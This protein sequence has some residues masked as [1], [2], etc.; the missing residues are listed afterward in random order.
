MVTTTSSGLDS[1]QVPCVYSSI[2]KKEEHGFLSV[3]VPG[4]KEYY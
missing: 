1:Y 3:S 2:Q 4:S